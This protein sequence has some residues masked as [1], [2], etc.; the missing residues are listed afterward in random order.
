MPSA[1]Q[2]ASETIGAA[3]RTLATSASLRLKPTRAAQTAAKPAFDLSAKLAEAGWREADEALAKALRD[4]TALE[5]VSQSLGRK[6]NGGPLSAH[7]A[8]VEDALLAAS[9]SL[10]QAGRRRNLQRFAEVGA[11]ED[12]DARR[13]VLTTARKRPPIRVRIVAQ[14]VMRGLGADAEIVLKALAAPLRPNAGTARKAT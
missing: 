11:I 1:K 9:Q 10:R 4:F 8:Q 14:G 7:A 2:N 3:K 5:K 13:H 12:Y 6:L